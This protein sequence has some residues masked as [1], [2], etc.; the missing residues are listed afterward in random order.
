[1]L[2]LTHRT[3]LRI[4]EVP[5]AAEVGHHAHDINR[6]IHLGEGL[7]VARHSCLEIGQHVAQC[8]RARAGREGFDLAAL[9]PHDGCLVGA[10]VLDD[11]DVGL[12]C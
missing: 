3:L 11:L 4:I 5:V 12:V 7:L 2:P 10:R 1:M 9:G 6:N 8:K